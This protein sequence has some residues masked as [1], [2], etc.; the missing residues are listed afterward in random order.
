MAGKYPYIPTNFRCPQ[1]PER[2]SHLPVCPVH[3]PRIRD[4]GY[5]LNIHKSVPTPPDGHDPSPLQ[6]YHIGHGTGKWH[7]PVKSGSLLSLFHKKYPEAHRFSARSPGLPT[8][9]AINRLSLVG[10]CK[11]N[12]FGYRQ[13]F[14]LIFWG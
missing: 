3:N 7:N 12:C 13:I 6:G 8:E 10:F 9:A 5:R 2:G 11:G 4:K 14:L 1:K